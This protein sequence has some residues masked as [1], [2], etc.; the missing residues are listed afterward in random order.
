VRAARDTGR[1]CW[2]ESN[3]GSEAELGG[4]LLVVKYYPA[5]IG[6]VWCIYRPGMIVGGS[7]SS[8]AAA[9]RAASARARRAL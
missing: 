2:R 9:K 7:A 5:P 6:W 3:G 1:V 8:E 4:L